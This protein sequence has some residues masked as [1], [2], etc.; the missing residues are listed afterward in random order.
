MCHK[1]QQWRPQG[2]QLPPGLIGQQRC[3]PPINIGGR[4]VGLCSPF[5]RCKRPCHLCGVH[6]GNPS[7]MPVHINVTSSAVVNSGVTV[8]HKCAHTLALYAFGKNWQKVTESIVPE[9]GIYRACLGHPS[10]CL[11]RSA[12]VP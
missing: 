3:A 4:Q 11:L 7:G 5:T 9:R 2:L 10:Y 6:D 1:R 8:F 12:A